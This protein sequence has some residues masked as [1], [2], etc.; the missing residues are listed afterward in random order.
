SVKPESVAEVN[1]VEQGKEKEE[2]EK[3]G[4]G[5]TLKAIANK[6]RNQLFL[7]SLMIK[8]I[9][10]MKNSNSINNE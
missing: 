1:E 3:E 5:L 4:E 6:L 9:P 2:E 7:W 8:N 10:S